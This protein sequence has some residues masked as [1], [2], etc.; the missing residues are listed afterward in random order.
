MYMPGVYGAA[1]ACSSARD[2][3][4]PSWFE[5]AA[6]RR[7]SADT[8]RI[9]IMVSFASPLRNG[10]FFLHSAALLFVL[11]YSLFSSLFLSTNKY[12]DSRLKKPRR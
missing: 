5:R 6:E 1:V 4:C 8:M 3:T 9:K 2:G 12:K 11:F 7:Y 10:H